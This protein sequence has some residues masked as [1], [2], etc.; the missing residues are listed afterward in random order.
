[1][2]LYATQ[3]SDADAMKNKFMIQAAKIGDHPQDMAIFWEDMKQRK[4]E[5]RSKI[6]KVNIVED[7]RPEGEKRDKKKSKWALLNEKFMKNLVTRRG[8]S[9]DNMLKGF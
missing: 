5:I 1:M 4:A 9:E 7:I 8:V 6:M 2:Q 3:S